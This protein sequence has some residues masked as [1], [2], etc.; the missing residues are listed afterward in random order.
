MALSL[1]PSHLTPEHLEA[2]YPIHWDIELQQTVRFWL[3]DLQNGMRPLTLR[4]IQTT[5]ERF[6]R[7]TLIL[8]TA[9]N[10][11]S[12][13]LATCLDLKIVYDVISSFPIESYSNRHNTFYAIFSL[14]RYLLIR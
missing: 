7:Y 9:Y 10:Y 14:A 12:L 4:T 1:F 13:S 2:A 3:K 6:F 5:R 8:K 11:N